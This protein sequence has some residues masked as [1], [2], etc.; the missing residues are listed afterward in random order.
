MW[1]SV[2]SALQ[3]STDCPCQDSAL[4]LPTSSIFT[5][6]ACLLGLTVAL[7]FWVFFFL[8]SPSSSLICIFSNTYNS[9]QG[10]V[11]PQ[12]STILL[13]PIIFFQVRLLQHIIKSSGY[14]EMLQ[15]IK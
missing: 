15:S 10:Q 11:N 14:F 8:I 13:F 7:F 3:V 9:G 5:P 1:T 2:G 6:M 12:K 4:R